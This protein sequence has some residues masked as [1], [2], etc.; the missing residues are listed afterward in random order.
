METRRSRRRSAVSIASL[1]S[2]SRVILIKCSFTKV[3][4]SLVL[5]C[6]LSCYDQDERS[7]VCLA[8]MKGVDCTKHKC[9]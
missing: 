9:D 8:M 3:S 2:Q 4:N 6:L 1:Q 5:L 7:L